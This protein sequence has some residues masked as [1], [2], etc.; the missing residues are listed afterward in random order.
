MG[1]CGSKIHPIHTHVESKCNR[2]NSQGNNDPTPLRSEHRKVSWDT[3]IAD[4]N[5]RFLI[6]QGNRTIIRDENCDVFVES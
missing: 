1:I 6:M 5:P 4:G 2:Q 3:L